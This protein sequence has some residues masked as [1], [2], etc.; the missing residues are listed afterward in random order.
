MCELWPQGGPAHAGSLAVSHEEGSTET[1]NEMSEPKPG[2]SRWDPRCGRVPMGPPPPAALTALC[3]GP[4]GTDLASPRARGVTRA[5]LG[6]TAASGHARW[7]S[8]AWR[9]RRGGWHPGGCRSGERRGQH[10]PPQTSTDLRTHPRTAELCDPGVPSRETW[11]YHKDSGSLTLESGTGGRTACTSQ[12]GSL[13]QT[14]QGP[15]LRP[16]VAGGEPRWD[17]ALHARLGVGC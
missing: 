7:S 3:A 4:T 9:Q 2:G 1:T 14:L 5:Q 10:V 17:R 16:H 13:S 12:S 8:C 6:R 15:S 11:P